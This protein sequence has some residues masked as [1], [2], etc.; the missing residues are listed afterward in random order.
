LGNSTIGKREDVEGKGLIHRIKWAKKG[1]LD[2]IYVLNFLI[3][4]QIRKK[5]RKKLIALFVQ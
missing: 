4:R 3:N 1:T 5:R 2:N